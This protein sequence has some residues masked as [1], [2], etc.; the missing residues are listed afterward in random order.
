MAN[1]N[2]ENEDAPPPLSMQQFIELG[3]LP[4]FLRDLQ[5]FDG[6]PTELLNWLT[7]VEGVIDMYRAAGATIAQLELIGRCVRRRIRGEAADILNSNNIT[8]HWNHIKSTLLLYYR[9]KRDLKTLDFELTSIRKTHNESLGSYYSRVNE[10]QSAIIA[11]VQTEPKFFLHANS[12]IDYFKEKSIDAFIRGLEKPLCQL[13]KTFNPKTLNQAYQFCLEYFNM[14]SRSA[15]YRNEYTPH[16]PK[17]RDIEI[18][19][20]LPPRKTPHPHPTIPRNYAW[21]HTQMPMFYPQFQPH[22]FQPRPPQFQS[23]PANPFQ[24]FSNSRPLP[25]PEPMD[26]DPSI[27]SKNINYGNRPPMG[28]KRQAPFSHPTNFKPMAHPLEYGHYY[29]NFYPDYMSDFY[30]QYEPQEQQVQPDAFHQ[31]ETA[32]EETPVIQEN[33]PQ[34][35]S[36]Q[37]NFLEWKP[38]W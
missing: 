4:D 10:L 9:D 2:V 22:V 1:A 17:P 26:I 29:G 18:P 19:P 28:Q 8:Y 38:S 11:Q 25:K 30:Y 37:T 16:I 3:K 13:L 33:E 5:P 12:H 34:P 7:D 31:E 20:K 23:R 35:S 15:P 21:P 36:T 27:R 6:K 24:N 14:D 32:T